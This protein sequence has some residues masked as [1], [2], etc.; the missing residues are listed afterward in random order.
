MSYPNSSRSRSGSC[1]VDSKVFELKRKQ[2]P[3]WEIAP[4]N[5]TDTPLRGGFTWQVCVPGEALPCHRDSN[6]TSQ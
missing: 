6:R 3:P 5:G 1:R 4:G 2:E